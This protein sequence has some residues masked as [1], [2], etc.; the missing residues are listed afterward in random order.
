MVDGERHS[1]VER[2]NA[3]YLNL[4][5]GGPGVNDSG[6]DHANPKF[7]SALCDSL[8]GIYGKFCLTNLMVRQAFCLFRQDYA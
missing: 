1:N 2:D 8:P 3:P 5:G 4:F 6:V 7:G